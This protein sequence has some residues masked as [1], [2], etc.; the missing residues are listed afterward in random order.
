M[1]PKLKL[2]FIAS[3]LI[4]LLN[5]SCTKI[6]NDELP[7]QDPKLV[8]NGILCP[9]SILKINLS[10]TVSIFENESSTNLPYIHGAIA[11]F[12][13]DGAFLFN[14]EEADNGYYS[15]PGFY[16]SLNHSY[17]VEVSKSGYNTVNAETTIPSPVV[18]QRIDTTITTEN[19]EFYSNKIIECILKYKDTPGVE[20]FY[21]LDCYVSYAGFDKQ[22]I[23]Y[24]QYIFVNENEAYLFDKSNDYLLWSD[25]LTD[26]NLVNL[27]FSIYLDY[28]YDNFKSNLNSTEITY[29]LIL[30]S[31]SKEYYQYDKTR[32]IFYESGGSD[33][34]FSEPV[35]IYTNIQ[36]GYGIFGGSSSDSISFQYVLNKQNQ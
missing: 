36:N 32:S 5:A 31:V 10:K 24:R 26:G 22:D 8:V 16:P 23:K 18:I 4:V 6:L 12:F 13:Q 11:G 17:Q 2:I 14:L 27:K 33:N 25:L 21:R 15:K 20:N 7:V 1:L 19:G 34:P 3:I 9:D 35:L 30:N 28:F 29:T